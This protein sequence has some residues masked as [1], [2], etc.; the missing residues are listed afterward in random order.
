MPPAFAVCGGTFIHITQ[1]AAALPAA[2]LIA[3]YA[4]REH[5]ALAIGALLALTVPWGWVVSPALI[6]A[7]LVP[8]GY[9][10]WRFWS[11][12]LAAVLV[13]A[14]A[15]GALL[16]GLGRLYAVKSPHVAVH[17]P[18][19]AIDARLAEAS[20]SDYSRGGS[21]ASIAAWAVR[22][23]TWGALVLLLVVLA[24]EVTLTTAP[25]RI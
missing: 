2:L 12:N 22:V 15:A 3:T 6:V 9:L 14:L 10:A 20:W 24:G 1:I 5:A 7:P 19:P 11:A 17:A 18:A 4:R 8:V 25:A 13:A 16:L 21:T 23:P